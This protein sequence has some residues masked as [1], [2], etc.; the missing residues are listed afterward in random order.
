MNETAR[1]PNAGSGSQR[2][3]R[4]SPRSQW[5]FYSVNTPYRRVQPVVLAMVLV[6]ALPVAVPAPMVHSPSV[7]SRGGTASGTCAPAKSSAWGRTSAPAR[8]GCRCRTATCGRFRCAAATPPPRRP[9][10]LLHPRGSPL[11][12]RL[13]RT[14]TRTRILPPPH[15]QS[16]LRRGQRR[17]CRPC[18]SLEPRLRSEDGVGVGARLTERVTLG[19]SNDINDVVRPTSS[20]RPPRNALRRRKA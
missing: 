11:R 12:A 3:Q 2:P 15:R 8:S 4:C 6:L 1:W 18:H 9:P 10:P 17:T 5:L 16:H 19:G 7:P 20:L 14:R 13:P